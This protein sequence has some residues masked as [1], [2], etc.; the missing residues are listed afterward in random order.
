MKRILAMILTLVIVLSLC[1][2]GTSAPKLVV[3]DTVKTD[4]VELTIENAQLTYY[5]SAVESSY[6]E[7]IA[8]SDGGIFATN[9]GRTFVALTFTITN[10]DR[11]SL[12]F[13][14]FA[15]D[16]Y[17]NW[18]VKYGNKSYPINT[19]DLNNIDGEPQL[20]LIYSAIS[21]DGGKTFEKYNMVNY[22]LEAG[23]TITVRTVGLVVMEPD[24]LDDAFDLIIN[25]PN[26]S[27]K[28]EQYVYSV[29]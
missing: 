8:E 2:C 25:I 6:C 4:I 22:I 11:N 5:A 27:S 13:G 23:E 19:Y 9:K 10:T 26:S 12:N 18:A 28:E 24:S 21:K 15:C 16:W 3:G 7:P 1:G 29:N 14:N 17:V 20:S